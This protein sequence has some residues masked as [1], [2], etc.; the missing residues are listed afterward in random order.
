[1]NEKEY[2]KNILAYFA[3]AALGVQAGVSISN[4]SKTNNN[5]PTLNVVFP[6]KAIIEETT[7][8]NTITANKVFEA[9]THVITYYHVEKD[10][11]NHEM[12]DHYLPTDVLIPYGYEIFEKQ[13]GIVYDNG[14][15]YVTL[16]SLVNNRTLEVVGTYDYDTNDF[17]FDGPGEVIE[18]YSLTLK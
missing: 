1:M 16:Y 10:L 9:G 3:A 12:E 6:E 4:L 18:D 14:A 13:T 11:M 5:E 17:V 8:D 15:Y 7:S 2:L